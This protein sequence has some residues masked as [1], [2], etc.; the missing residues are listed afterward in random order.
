MKKRINGR[1]YN[2]NTARRQKT[3]DFRGGPKPDVMAYIREMAT[4]VYT[5]C[6]TSYL[7]QTLYQ[8]RNGEHFLHSRYMAAG[9][10][11]VIVSEEII[12]LTATQ[13]KLWHENDGAYCMC[14]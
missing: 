14:A 4:G 11:P 6:D 3:Y 9:S 12:P 2:T 5:P 10:E 7:R 8:K 13:A 1:E